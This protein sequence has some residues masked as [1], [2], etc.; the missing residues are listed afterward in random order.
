[1]ETARCPIRRTREW[2][3]RRD[4]DEIRYE[5]HGRRRRLGRKRRLNSGQWFPRR[6]KFEKRLAG[7]SIVRFSSKRTGA[8]AYF[9][10]IT[11]RYERV[12][13]AVSFFV[14]T[15]RRFIYRARDDRITSSSGKKSAL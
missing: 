4:V 9:T 1:M 8:A 12:V 15:K 11:R 5:I 3:G 7:E 14:I 10:T 13:R 6:V 2:A